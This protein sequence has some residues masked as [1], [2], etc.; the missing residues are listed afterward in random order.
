M[1]IETISFY[2]IFYLAVMGLVAKVKE[3]EHHKPNTAKVN[4]NVFHVIFIGV[5]ADSINIV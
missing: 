1:R 4:D 2:K 3:Q 5:A